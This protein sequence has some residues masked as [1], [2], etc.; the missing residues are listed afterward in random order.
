MSFALPIQIKDSGLRRCGVAF[1]VGERPLP[2]AR[3]K[4]GY[5][6]D[7]PLLVR[8]DRC[9]RYGVEII[10]WMLLH[11]VDFEVAHTPHPSGTIKEPAVLQVLAGRLLWSLEHSSI[12][13]FCVIAQ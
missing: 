4:H 7:P 6:C 3:E 12:L 8:R 9:F 2:S 11:D 10:D 13:D 1:L 5:W